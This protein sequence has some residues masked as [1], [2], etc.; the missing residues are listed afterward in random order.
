MSAMLHLMP[1]RQNVLWP[2]SVRE[3]Y[4]VIVS[5]PRQSLFQSTQPGSALTCRIGR[6]R[7]ACSYLV[8]CTQVDWGRV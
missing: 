7:V 5:G 8:V 4:K 2:L 1:T 3:L 6:V